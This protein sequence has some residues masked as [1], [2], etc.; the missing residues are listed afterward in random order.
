MNKKSL[1]ILS[2]T[3]FALMGLARTECAAETLEACK[4][5]CRNT[6][7]S[8]AETF[9]DQRIRNIKCGTPFGECDRNCA[10]NK[11]GNR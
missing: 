10:F 5:N 3:I 4:K 7:N 11:M 1:Q 6:Y 2:V 8:C 9:K